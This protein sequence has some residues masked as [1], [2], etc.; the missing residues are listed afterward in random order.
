MRLPLVYF[1]PLVYQ[2][3]E[4]VAKEEAVIFYFKVV[5]VGLLILLIQLH[6]KL[7]L[8]DR[9]RSVRPNHS[10]L[11]SQPWLFSWPFVEGFGSREGLKSGYFFMLKPFLFRSFLNLN[12]SRRE[13]L[14]LNLSI[15]WITNIP[16][17]V[18]NFFDI[19]KTKLFFDKRLIFNNLTT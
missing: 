16:D 2:F 4:V 9:R 19:L 17:N 12:Y 18:D 13:K 11:L 3:L 6:W 5:R 8:T 10:W 15:F 14:Y 7:L 1:D